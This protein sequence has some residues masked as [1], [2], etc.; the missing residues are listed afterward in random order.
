MLS[1]LRL[2]T[3]THLAFLRRNQILLGFSLLISIGT[4]ILL[5]PSALL[6][7]AASRFDVL[8]DIAEVLHLLIAFVTAGLGLFIL[9]SH[10]RARSIKMI[11]T[12]PR[13]FVAWVAS[14]FVAV[15]I[16][17]AVAHAGIALIVAIV[18]WYWGISYQYGFLFLAL[19]SF[20]G[21]MIAVA[22]FT[23][24]SAVTHPVLAVLL[25]AIVGEQTTMNLWELVERIDAG[26]HARGALRAF[27]AVARTLYYVMPTFWPYGDRITLG[28]SMRVPASDWRHLGVGALYALLVCACSLVATTGVL[29]RRPLT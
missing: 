1:A 5:V 29:R 19:V 13:P 9:W 16:V 26:S 21:S 3:S 23:F 4:A 17:A 15:A 12:A 25:V 2:H 7:T 22:A 18:S 14:I 10:R 6:N 20:V 11:A 27:G 8:S 24:L 28:G